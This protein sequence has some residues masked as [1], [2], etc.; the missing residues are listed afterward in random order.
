ME[1]NELKPH[2]GNEEGSGLI[3][4]YLG[5]S[6]VHQNLDKRA[7]L[8]YVSTREPATAAGIESA[9]SSLAVQLATEPARGGSR[10]EQVLKAH[11]TTRHKQNST[12]NTLI[13]SDATVS[14]KRVFVSIVQ[15]VKLLYL[16]CYHE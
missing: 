6:H 8:L 2:L 3:F 15:N 14:V 9:S 13:G 12:D 7:C 5:I 1:I 11:D 10:G 16:I 4:D